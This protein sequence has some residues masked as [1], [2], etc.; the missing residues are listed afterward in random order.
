MVDN[1]I[2]MK[3]CL[4]ISFNNFWGKKIIKNNLMLIKTIICIETL[5]I[6]SVLDRL[7]IWVDCPNRKRIYFL[8]EEMISKRNWINWDPKT[9]VL[10][11]NKNNKLKLVSMIFLKRINRFNLIK[12]TKIQSLN[13]TIWRI[14]TRVSEI[15]Y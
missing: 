3:E 8:I 5:W 9:I 7:R 11:F 10:Y 2:T 4:K 12:N 1:K 13:R 15:N 6:S 14:K